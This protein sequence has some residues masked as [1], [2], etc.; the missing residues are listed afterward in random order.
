M[1]IFINN[2]ETEVAGRISLKEVLASL[3]NIPESGFA[4]AINGDVVPASK[5]K[6]T[7]VSENDSITLIRAFYGG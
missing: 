1:K 2:K 7:M 5:W 4:V 3:D 6:E